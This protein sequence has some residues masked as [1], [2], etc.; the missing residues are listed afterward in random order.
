M[1]N[2]DEPQQD[3]VDPLPESQPKVLET[4][5]HNLMTLYQDDA[6]SQGTVTLDPVTHVA[7]SKLVIHKATVTTSKCVTGQL[8]TSRE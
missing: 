5:Q 1:E 8:V 4:V 3:Y 2:T 7:N 6:E